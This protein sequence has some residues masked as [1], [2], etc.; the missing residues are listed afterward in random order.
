MEAAM[1]PMITAVILA[2]AYGLKPKLAGMM[3]GVGIP[4][5]FATIAIW[6]YILNTF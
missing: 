4:L 5:S 2:S 6:Y 1:A 3:I